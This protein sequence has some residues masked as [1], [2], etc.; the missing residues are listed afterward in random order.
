MVAFSS[1]S[2]SAARERTARAARFD[3]GARSAAAGRATGARTACDVISDGA[4]KPKQVDPCVVSVAPPNTSPRLA[5]RCF[6]A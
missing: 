3:R 1:V 6:R 4:E 2:T 5:F